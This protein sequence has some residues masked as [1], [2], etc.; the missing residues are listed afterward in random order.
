M[1][2]RVLTC[3]RCSWWQIQ[4][5]GGTIENALLDA[6]FAAGMITEEN[7]K[8][9]Q[10][11]NFQRCARTDKGVHAARQVVSL[12]VRG[13]TTRRRCGV[14]WRVEVGVERAKLVFP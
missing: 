6:L 8:K 12:K 1:G 11:M 2:L 10:T 14:V 9:I 7:N 3:T 4:P 13:H 5:D